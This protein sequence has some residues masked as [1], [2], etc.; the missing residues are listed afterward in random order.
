MQLAF[1]VSGYLKKHAQSWM[2]F[3]ATVPAIDQLHFRVVDW[4]EFYPEASR[5][6]RSLS[7]DLLLCRL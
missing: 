6:E 5:M 7:C 3:D 2:V 4:A 1:H